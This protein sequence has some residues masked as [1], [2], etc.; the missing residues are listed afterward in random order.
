MLPLPEPKS[1]PDTSRPMTSPAWRSSRRSTPMTAALCRLAN[2]SQIHRTHLLKEKSGTTKRA[3]H[4]RNPHT[5]RALNTECC[6]ASAAARKIR[7]SARAALC[8]AEPRRSRSLRTSERHDRSCNGEQHAQSCHTSDNAWISW[9]A[10]LSS[11][12]AI[13][14]STLQFQRLITDQPQ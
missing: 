4:N 6:A 11:E 12:D 1:A 13:P 14:S 9:P 5:T 2:I 3:A 7:R 10:S 8:H